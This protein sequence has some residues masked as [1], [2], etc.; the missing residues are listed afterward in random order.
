MVKIYIFLIFVLFSIAVNAQCP[1]GGKVNC[2]HGCGRFTDENKD[3]YCDYGT[4]ET[5]QTESAINRNAIQ[6]SEVKIVK[7]R[8]ENKEKQEN[9]SVNKQVVE[10]DSNAQT[11]ELIQQID[12]GVEALDV[13][14]CPDKAEK[15]NVKKYDFL[16]ILFITIAL[17][18]LTFILVQINKI[19]KQT[20]RKIWNT[21]LLLTF[22]TSCL[23]GLI[24]VLQLNYGI[25][26]SIFS[27]FLYLHVEFGIAM[28]IIG[29]IHVI[30]HI[31]YYKNILK[32]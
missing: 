9:K 23:L 4:I 12:K 8:L 29:I 13:T 25:L 28:T 17:Y 31:P 7:K 22:V 32:K 18:I 15:N 24:L 20:H 6:K 19:K 3:G 21:I 27:T 2:Q 5:A 11:E 26:S 10:P 16:T 30:W 14:A 1:F